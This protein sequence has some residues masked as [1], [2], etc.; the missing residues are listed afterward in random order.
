M[1]TSRTNP[2]PWVATGLTLGLAM[3]SLEGRLAEADR[4]RTAALDSSPCTSPARFCAHQNR[5]KRSL[6]REDE[7]EGDREEEKEE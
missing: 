1:T 4:G 3:L 2:S 7:E 6:M 5:N